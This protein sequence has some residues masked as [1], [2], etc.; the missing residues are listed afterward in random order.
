MRMNKTQTFE[1]RTGVRF[2]LLCI[3]AALI[4]YMSMYAFRK[5]LSA[6]TFEGLTYWGMDYKIIAL[7]SQVI[8]YTCSKF[9]GI[10]IVSSMKPGQRIRYILG[11]VGAAWIALF[12]FA[13]TPQPYNVLL[14]VIN[15]L[16]LGMIFGIVISFLEGRRN[17]ELLGAGLCISFITASGIVKSVGQ[18]LIVHLGVSDF[19]MPFLT[20]LVFVP[21][22]L[23]GVWL[24]GKIPP[25]T[26]ED[27]ALRSE[28]TP[29]TK[30]ERR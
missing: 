26:E 13:W 27:K 15:G 20:G 21:L 9:L 11:L 14:L 22:L 25:P 18:F 5:P 4:T 16:P 7:I 17:T 12:F 24:L 10:R 3:A 2:S 8:G 6:A 1:N 28:R 30:V 23:L 29:M 19:W